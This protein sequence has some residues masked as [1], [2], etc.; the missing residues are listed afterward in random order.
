MTLSIIV[1]FVCSLS[2]RPDRP[3]YSKIPRPR[4]QQR[5]E[6]HFVVSGELYLGTLSRTIPARYTMLR[7]HKGQISPV[8]SLK[9]L[10][11]FVTIRS[12]ADAVQ[13]VR[14]G[15]SPTTCTTLTNRSPYLELIPRE[16]LDSDFVFGSRPELSSDQRAADGVNAI[17]PGK[18]LSKWKIP[19]LVVLQSKDNWVITRSCVRYMGSLISEPNCRVIKLVE[20]VTRNGSYTLESQKEFPVR[21]PASVVFSAYS[22]K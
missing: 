1:I 6:C 8:T 17:W 21:L 14:L 12:G 4:L 2:Q 5:L 18:Q 9:S 20:S 15:T 10:K 13:F 7:Y 19:S 16:R 11:G 22:F 3:I